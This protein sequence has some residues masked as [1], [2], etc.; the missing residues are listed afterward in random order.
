MS[1]KVG[2]LLSGCGYQ[3]GSEVY[4]AVLTILALER[5]G[6]Q[7]RA[8]APDMDQNVVINH[9][10]GQ[11]ARGEALG[12]ASRVIAQ[13]ARIVRGKITSVGEVSGHDID[14]LIIPGGFGVVKNLCTF[15]TDGVDADVHPEVRRLITEMHSLEKPVGAICIAPV[16]IALVLGDK[17][18][19]LTI[20]N[21]G[22]VALALEK[23]GARH[24]ETTVDGIAVDTANKIVSTPAFML[25]QNALEAETGINKLVGKVLELAI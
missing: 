24:Q 7:V 11:E 16:L 19:T 5:A 17:N 6:A 9:Y 2:V 10:S 14:A 21:D 3:D 15:A 18:P 12:P 1:K 20:G 25:A 8:L 23:L 22:K 13:S 4:E